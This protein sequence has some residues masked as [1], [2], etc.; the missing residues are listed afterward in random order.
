MSILMG[1][2]NCSVMT[3][4]MVFLWNTNVFKVSCCGGVVGCSWN[5]NVFFVCNL[6]VSGDWNISRDCVCLISVDISWDWEGIDERMMFSD[7]VVLEGVDSV[8]LLFFLLVLV[9]V[10]VTCIIGLTVCGFA[11]GVFI[12]VIA[13]LM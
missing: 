2:N 5:L 8:L 9:D 1:S 11:R 6:L 13:L 10:Q 7:I 12:A 3:L 4:A